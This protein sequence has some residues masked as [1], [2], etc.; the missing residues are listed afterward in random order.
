MGADSDTD[1]YPVVA[2]VRERLAASKQNM[3]R[4]YMER[5]SL[6]KLNKV[7]RVKSS[8]RLKSQIGSLLWKT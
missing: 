7:K 1:H 3:H 2:K 6:K 4:F 5:S 8:I